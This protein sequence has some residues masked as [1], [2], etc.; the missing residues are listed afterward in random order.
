MGHMPGI[1]RMKLDKILFRKA[2]EGTYKYERLTASQCNFRIEQGHKVQ[3]RDIFGSLMAAHDVET[4]RS[5]N[6]EELVAEAMLD[7]S[8]E[9]ASPSKSGI[10]VVDDML[11]YA[12][13]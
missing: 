2:T 5:L 7:D 6:R 9:V 3:E 13:V 10:E 12:L 8:V 4:N 1:L 11:Q